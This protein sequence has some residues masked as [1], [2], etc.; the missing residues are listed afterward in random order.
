LE[1]RSDSAARYAPVTQKRVYTSSR[2]RQSLE[3]LLVDKGGEGSGGQPDLKNDPIMCR[4]DMWPQKPKRKLSCS[5]E[6]KTRGSA[7]KKKIKLMAGEQIT[8][9]PPQKNDTESQKGRWG[10]AHSAL[11]TTG[12]RHSEPNHCD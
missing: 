9:P 7:K 6:L 5:G 8:S 3:V 11:T 12:H 4:S 1:P 2:Y 10:E